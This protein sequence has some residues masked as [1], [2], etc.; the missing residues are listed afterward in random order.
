MAHFFGQLIYSNYAIINQ[1]NQLAHQE[2]IAP[3]STP[4]NISLLETYLGNY[5]KMQDSNHDL[6]S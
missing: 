3:K 4:Y 1:S 2:H 5:V 6:W